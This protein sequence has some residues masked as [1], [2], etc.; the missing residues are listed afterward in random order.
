MAQHRLSAFRI[1]CGNAICLDIFLA[2]EFKFFFYLDFNWQAVAVPAG[3]TLNMKTFHGAIARE[4]VL[5]CS[6][7][8]VMCPGHAI[9]GRWTFVEHPI[10]LAS[11]LRHGARKNLLLPPKFQ[12][13]RFQCRQ[14]NTRGDLVVLGHCAPAINLTR[15]AR[16]RV[17]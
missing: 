5:K 13:L 14:V 7:F 9:S 12:H 11:R 1:K 15:A 8:N 17:A 6:S 10:W 4:D 2:V 3:A 16:Y